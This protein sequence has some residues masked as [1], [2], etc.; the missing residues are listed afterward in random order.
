MLPCRE[1][2]VLKII[3]EIKTYD[4]EC[5]MA[6]YFLLD[7]FMYVLHAH[8]TVISLASSNLQLYL[9]NIVLL[10]EKSYVFKI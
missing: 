6:T 3:R 4:Y 9:F 2:F 1:D 7:V 8:C 10:V 5:D